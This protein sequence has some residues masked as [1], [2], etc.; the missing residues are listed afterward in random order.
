M[1]INRETTI[2]FLLKEDKVLLAMKK[3]GFGKGRWNGYGGKAKPNESVEQSAVR[4]TR[5]ESGVTI[6]ETALEKVAVLD[7]R[8]IHRPEWSLRTHVFLVRTWNGEP[9]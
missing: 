9:Q 2:C 4:E 3:R 8:F 6:E 5:E 7:F 1:D